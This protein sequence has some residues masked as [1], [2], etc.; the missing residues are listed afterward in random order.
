M[1][2]IG[3]HVVLVTQ[4]TDT[5]FQS[6]E[7]QPVG[8]V[9]SRRAQDADTRTTT[10]TEPAQLSLRINTTPRAGGRRTRV[11]RLVDAFAGTIA[12]DAAGTYVH[13][14]LW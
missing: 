12:V 3:E 14:S 11:E 1:D 10:H 8:G 5:L 13:K 7:R 9:D 2:V 4:R 6:L